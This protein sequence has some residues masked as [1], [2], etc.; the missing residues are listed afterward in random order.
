MKK[1][2]SYCRCST[3]KQDVS[4]A[5]QREVIEK[6]CQENHIKL[7]KSFQDEG[8]SGITSEKRP[9]FMAMV[10][11][12]KKNFDDFDYVLVYD[13]SRFGRFN[14]PKEAVY[15]EYEIERYDKKIIYVSDPTANLSGIGGDITRTV[16]HYEASEFS[17]KLRENTIRGSEFIAKKGFHIGS[18][19]Y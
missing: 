14:N 2:I 18:T 6:Y 12:V 8:I 7:I 5:Q 13:Q 9:G 10:D 17:K 3:D 1:A 11:F 4:I 19:P 16:R 15:W